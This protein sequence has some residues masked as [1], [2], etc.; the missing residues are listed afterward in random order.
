MSEVRGQRS[1]IRGQRSEVGSQ[2]VRKLEKETVKM[3][4]VKPF[5]E[6]TVNCGVES[7]LLKEFMTERKVSSE[8]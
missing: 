5:I 2:K 6:F 8:L 4:Q 7:G 3:G 1:E